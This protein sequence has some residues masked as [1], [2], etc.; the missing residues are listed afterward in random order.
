MKYDK[1]SI[2][3]QNVETKR[4]NPAIPVLIA[5]AAVAAVILIGRLALGNQIWVQSS[6]F[7]TLDPL[8]QDFKEN[9]DAEG[10]SWPSVK[11][12][13]EMF[14]D[15]RVGYDGEAGTITV[16]YSDPIPIK[17]WN[18]A[19]AR[20]QAFKLSRRIYQ[21]TDGEFDCTVLLFKND[22]KDTLFYRSHNG[23]WITK[24]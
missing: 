1:K 13:N 22:K 21:Q 14:Y 4:M 15:V 18:T 23:I 12:L 3:T 2:Y 19:N 16:V 5:I 17:N 9:F 6:V 8:M 7:G 11:E 20:I 10:Y 24:E